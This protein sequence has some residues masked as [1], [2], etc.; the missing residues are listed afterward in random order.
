MHLPYVRRHTRGH[1]LLATLLLLPVAV[2]AVPADAA[3]PPRAA[4]PARTTPYDVTIKIT[5]HGIPHVR[6]ATFPGVAYGAGWIT[7]AEATCTLMDTLVTAR[8]QRSLHYGSDATYR[9][10]VGGS[11]TNLEW[12]TLVTDLHDRRVVEKLLADPVAGPSAR[13]KAMVV[14]ETAGIN[15][16][17]RDHEVTDPACADEEWIRPDVTTTDVWY[18]F[19]L[20]QL[21]SSTSR[22]LPQITSATP[23]AAGARPAPRP[24]RAEVR[25]A[26]EQDDAF[27]S[28]ATAVGGADTSTRRGMILGNPHF[29]W[30]GRYRFTQLHLTVPGK[31]NVAGGA[32]TGFPA[33]NIGF[34][35]DVAWSHTVSTGYRFTPYQ[36]TT[37]GTPTSYRTAG[38]QTAELERRDVQVDVGTDTGV[39]T[40]TRTLWRTP[41]GYVLNAPSLFMGWT[42]DS[43]WAFRDAN[44]EH[45]RTF[46]T[47]LSMDMASSVGNL[48][49]RQDRGGGMPWVNTIA[50]D[51][52]GDVLYA[53]H[54]VT[55][56]VTD[57][58]ADRCMTGA[59]RLIFG[60]AGLPGLDGTRAGT[61]CAWGTDK[62][63]QRPGILGPS[64]L[65]EVVR[66]DWVM[67][68][69]DSYWMPNDR[70]RLTGYPRIIGCESC[71]RTMRTKVVMAYVRDRLKVG[72]ENPATLAS[73]EH[74]NRVYAAEVARAGGRLDQVCAATG[75]AEA[76]R[77]LHDWDGHSD[78][79]SSA[80][81]AI[82]QEFV[83]LAD[84][85][86]VRLWEVPFSAAQPL[87]T[88]RTLST[89]QPVV[90]AMAAAIARVTDRDP[91]LTATYGELHRS[92]DRG[93]AGWPL[94]GG[95]GDL[96]GD[97]NAVSSTLGDPV[98]D[99][100]TRGSS[101]IQAIAFRG[102]EEVV[103]RTIL[104]YSQ[105]EDPASPW[106]DDQTRMFSQ[107]RW[108][109]FPWTAAQ[110][111]EQLVTTLHLTG[112]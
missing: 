79:T 38:G 97:A 81:A 9:D 45:L 106:S 68:A 16:W 26:L 50:A 86:D 112:D 39:E 2:A 53:D 5:E 88:P 103:A 91:D 74:A 3:P 30:L 1:L 29:P 43:F 41:E 7:T 94:G 20:A 23:P 63:A 72:K 34:N 21:I 35:K 47:F 66:R 99:P 25:E 27:G 48:L 107:E 17:L 108:V 102:T 69:N 57:Q 76:C 10:N 54:A 13:A 90:D 110:I 49:R 12:D 22:L 40:V 59:G 62:D 32:L 31:M 24:T 55:P 67:N 15:D 58:L 8:G 42:N 19:Y 65:P 100:V 93:S 89:S 4:A 80:G 104:T 92:G 60:I 28:N 95:L 77:V 52:T 36:Y 61:T 51:R 111:K 98:L 101:Y 70:V 11:A 37:A 33:V 71:E 64:H 109:R 96:S 46:D 78:A 83:A 6:S 73:H 56:N 82:F 105:Y 44:V 18:A 87:T 85:R 84:Q 75:L 14:A